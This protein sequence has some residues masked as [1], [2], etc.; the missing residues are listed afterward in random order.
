VRFEGVAAFEFTR[1]VAEE[2]P[3]R[4]TGTPAAHRAAN[5]LRAQL[6]NSGYAVILE[7][8]PLWLRGKQVQG[9]NVIA[10]EDGDFPES[11][12]II[13]HYDSQFTSH[14][15]A[16]DNAAGV[17]VLLELA[18]VLRLS[19]HSH[20]LIL[21]ATDA[22]EWGMIGAR[23]LAGFLKR[24]H[25]EAVISIKYVMA[26]PPRSL[27]MNCM[28]QFAGYTPL[29]LRQLLVVSGRAQGASVE[30][31]T[32]RQEWIERA[33]EVS[34]QDQGPLLR[35]GIPAV[36]VG[37]LS[38]QMEASLRRH[39]T[40]DD[41]FRDFDPAAFQM[42]GATVEQA[43]LTLDRHPLLVQGTTGSLPSA[44]VQT[45]RATAWF[46]S[47]DAED[48]Q[49]SPTSYLPGELIYA[50]Q[51]LFLLPL[52]LAAFFAAH[53]FAAADLD[54][55]GWRF[56]E[57]VSWIIPPGLATL[58]LYGL[59]EMNALPRYELY[60]ATP[61]DPFLYHLPFALLALLV[62]VIAVGSVELQ[63]LRARVDAP[64]VPFVVKKRILFLWVAMV[65]LVGFFNTPSAMGLFLGA[66]AAAARRGAEA[67][68]CRPAH[69]CHCAFRR[70]SP[71]P[72]PENVPGV[73]HRLVPRVGNR[74]WGVV[75]RGHRLVP[76]GNCAGRTVVLDFG[77]GKEPGRRGVVAWRFVSSQ[78]FPKQS[79]AHSR[80][81]PLFFT[82]IQSIWYNKGLQTSNHNGLRP[83]R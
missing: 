15:A 12:A 78:A 51:L 42:V 53:N 8:F 1:V 55:R 43:V 2:F 50:I 27:K 37:M 6:R 7:P 17:G 81:L 32:G 31:A 54:L 35:A 40:T 25:T 59:T 77:S 80:N 30:Q 83:D 79:H 68:E 16:E 39:H 73:A 72:R 76:D 46:P 48:F 64:P 44:S 47:G 14:Q 56:F 5:Y 11:V 33:L 41:V 13:A 4:V 49:I 34:E 82:R 28:G 63:K 29:W 45:P 18:R 66:F 26:G 62:A 61:K 65:A 22:E 58:L 9:E 60:P 74:L 23:E 36:N 71:F 57:P 21:V 3:D 69:R 19:P 75:A 24:H 70:A 52:L 38:T 67:R 20:G 10:L